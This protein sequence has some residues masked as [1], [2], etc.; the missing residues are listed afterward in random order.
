MQVQDILARKGHQVYS[1]PPDCSVREAAAMIAARNIG[2]AVVISSQGALLGIISER[3]LL[4]SLHKVGGNLL[5]LPVS[6]LMTGRVV[7]CAPETDAR[8]A[9]S[10]MGAHRIRHLPV[11]HDGQILGLISVRDVLKFQLEVRE[12]QDRE[13]DRALLPTR[14]NGCT[15]PGVTP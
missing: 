5:K 9:L 15:A 14:P 1:V 3:D 6:V 10:L 4:R 7:T 11:V 12:E 8:D 2:V 13:S